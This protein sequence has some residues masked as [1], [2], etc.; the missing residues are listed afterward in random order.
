MIEV[1]R[2]GVETARERLHKVG[3]VERVVRSAI[4]RSRR[5][6]VVEFEQFARVHV[7]GEKAG[8]DVGHRRHLFAKPERRQGLHRLRADID[9]AADLAQG[10]RSLEYI[11]LE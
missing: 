8:K 1:E 11:R 10:R 7:A 3:A 5:A 2:F 9:T 6:A 4:A